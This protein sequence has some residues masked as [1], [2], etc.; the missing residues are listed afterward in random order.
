MGGLVIDRMERRKDKA[1]GSDD[2][3]ACML[4]ADPEFMSSVLGISTR[5]VAER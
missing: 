3:G 4:R 2:R 1:P 5:A